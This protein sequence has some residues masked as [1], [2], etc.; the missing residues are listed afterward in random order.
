MTNK[1][2]QLTSAALDEAAKGEII[3]RGSLVPETL[4]HLRVDDYQREVLPIRTIR[5]LM[6][7]FRDG[8]IPDIEL[9]MRGSRTRNAGDEYTLL[10][11]VYI[12]DGL[13]RRTAALELLRLGET[14]RLGAVVHFGTDRAW[15]QRQFQLLNSGR[16]LVS[17]SV[18][19]RNIRSEHVSLATLYN[20]SQ[21]E[22][23]VL[24]DRVCWGQRKGRT[25]F[26]SARSLLRVAGT[27]HTGLQSGLISPRPIEQIAAVD[28]LINDIGPGVFR[29]NVTAYFNV[30]DAA[31]GIRSVVFT[32]RAPQLRTGFLAA[33][34]R[35]LAEHTNFW[36]GARLSVS[37]DDQKKLSQFPLHDPEV[38]RL[39]GASSQALG[40][41]YQLLV[42]HMN[43]GRRAAN[44]LQPVEFG[45]V[46]KPRA[47]GAAAKPAKK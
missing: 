26:I 38:C 31:F 46:R 39:S 20:L 43:R 25:H 40:L 13:Q 33:A 4:Q 37:A 42:E 16:A 3:L 22:D 8:S 7:G 29:T 15:E 47:V 27:L 41:L 10:D 30:I 12:I 24:K 36:K 5:T 45:P 44:R 1:H 34:A 11:D 32:E 14:P 23:S 19:L 35:V 18:L 28:R 6:Q 17:P 2:V 21:A 9:G